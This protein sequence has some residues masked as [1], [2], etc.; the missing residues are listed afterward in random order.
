MTNFTR[1]KAKGEWVDYYRPY[2]KT[3]RHFKTSDVAR[4]ARYAVR[5][6]ADKTALIV[7]VIN[8]LELGID[9]CRAARLLSNVLILLNALQKIAAT[10]AG[11]QVVAILIRVLNGAK[12]VAPPPLRIALAAAIAAIVAIDK[13][14]DAA[15]ETY[16]DWDS[17]GG[18]HEILK[19][20]CARSSEQCDAASCY[21]ALTRTEI[22]L[23]DFLAA[24]DEAKQLD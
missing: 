20:L 13:I 18:V 21:P 19:A 17:I 9:S 16:S 6:G 7:A 14:L 3:V 10:L 2:R 23:T 15:M 12:V 4:I 8:A 24:A 11:G 22:S 5:D 1:P